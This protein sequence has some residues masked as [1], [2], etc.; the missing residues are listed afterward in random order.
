MKINNRLLVATGLAASALTAQ[1]ALTT[2]DSSAFANTYN[3]DEIF[4]GAATI[5]GWAAAG[6]ATNA[7]LTLNGSNVVSTLTD[8]NGWLQHDNGSTPWESGNGS[9]TVEVRANM[10]ATGTGGLNIWGALNGERDIMTIRENQV[11]NLGGTV[12]NTE[13][14]TGAFHNFRLAY[15]AADDVYHYFRDGVQITPLGGVP[16]Q[17]GTGSTRL[18]VGDCCT[19]AGGSTGG[20]FGGPGSSVEFAYI[21]YDNTGAFSPIPEP[22]TTAFFGL[23]GLAFLLRRR[24]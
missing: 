24:R 12:Y 1:A 4:D 17:G 9:W 5:N 18:I 22:S 14:N 6:G 8:T 10:S 11:S 15:D 23:A 20:A 3:G 13:S 7:N 16:Q 19:N 2:L 21:R